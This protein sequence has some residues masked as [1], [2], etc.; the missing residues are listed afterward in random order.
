MTLGAI[1]TIQTV[2]WKVTEALDSTPNTRREN[3]GSWEKYTPDIISKLNDT[4][5]VSAASEI[6][7]RT[8]TQEEKNAILKAHALWE[9]WIDN[10]SLQDIRWKVDILKQ[11]WFNAEERRVLM[12]KWVCW[13]DRS[14]SVWKSLLSE[15]RLDFLNKP[16]Y[17]ELRDLYGWDISIE[18][19]L[20][21]WQNA[22]ILEH[23]NKWS[24][25]LKVTKEWAYDDLIQEFTNHQRFYEVLEQWRIDF[26]QQLS[27]SI[28]IP[29]I[30]KWNWNNPIYFEMEKIDG[31]SFKS[32]F[33]R[34]HYAPQL[35]KM[36]NK[37][38]LGLMSDAELEKTIKKLWLDL[39]RV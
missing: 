20:W 13:M 29:E 3:I 10:Y 32:L 8:L 28:K 34:E 5:R 4:E 9:W 23:P 2:K 37:D 38:K 6:L 33:Y 22:I 19:L 11:S 21:E 18:K 39:F 30:K 15:P 27:D 14:I 24:K 12:E 35:E 36:Y 16:A 7:W 25:I 17:K 26:P 31:Q 1:E